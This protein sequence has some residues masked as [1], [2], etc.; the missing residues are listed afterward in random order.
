MYRFRMAKSKT[1]SIELAERLHTALRQLLDISDS[2]ME[3][4]KA[5]GSEEFVCSNYKQAVQGMSAIAKYVRDFAG[6]ATTAEIE[7]ELRSLEELVTTRK[8][9]AEKVDEATVSDK[10]LKKMP[11]RK[12]KES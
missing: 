9:L 6:A 11:R 10:P 1:V 7:H 5:N 4:L 8:T 12:S 3:T 2:G